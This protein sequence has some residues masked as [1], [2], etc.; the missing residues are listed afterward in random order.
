M[1]VGFTIVDAADYRLITV[2]GDIDTANAPSLK[3]ACSD[4]KRIIVDLL[5]CTYMDS[6]GLHALIAQSRQND[7]ELVLTARCRVYRIFEITELV[8][9]F[10]LS[11]TAQEAISRT[12]STPVYAADPTF[13]A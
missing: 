8:K 9:H 1:F 6:T 2:T 10:V 13:G 3:Q 11:D 5:N 4:A 12:T 7:I